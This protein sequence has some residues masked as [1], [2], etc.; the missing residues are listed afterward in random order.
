V[1]VEAIHL[2]ALHDSLDVTGT[3]ATK[4]ELRKLARLGAVTID[5]PYFDRFAIGVA[6]YLLK[7]P[8]AMS[9][10]GNLF[11][12][13]RPVGV[14]KSMLRQASKLRRAPST[15]ASGERVLAFALGYVS[16]VA[17]DRSMHPMV[18]RL[19]AIR[20]QRL[21][22]SA[23]RQHTEVEKFHSV[24]FHEQRKP[25]TLHRA[26]DLRTAY[27]AALTEAVGEAPVRSLLKRWAGGYAQYTWLVSTALGKTLVPEHVKREVRAEVF[28]G[29]DVSFAASYAVAVQCSKQSLA[30][31][32]QFC[33]AGESGESAFDALLPEGPID[34]S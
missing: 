3:L 12:E 32:L 17:V 14:C 2:S 29:P 23:S 27:L 28:E 6:R 22:D 31:A 18:N 25:H 1:P 13:T 4:L 8:T 20:A 10:W 19:A 34:G 5:F 16:H 26:D 33:E 30:A 7:R 9:D 15:R 21:G 11:H 24:L